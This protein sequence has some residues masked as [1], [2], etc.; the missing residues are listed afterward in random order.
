M[1]QQAFASLTASSHHLVLLVMLVTLL[2][3]SYT[4]IQRRRIPNWLTVSASLLGFI[5]AAW[6]GGTGALASSACGFLVWFGMGFLFYHRVGGIGAGDIKLIMALA[7][8]G[9]ALATLWIAFVSFVLQV[10][11]LLGSWV[12]RGT[13][14][15]N[16]QAVA[17]WFWVLL[18]P[19]A[20]K[21]HFVAIGTSDKSPHAP[22]LLLSTV[23]LLLC[24]R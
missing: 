17:R 14:R 11:W 20:D 23:I 24:E 21:A 22:F 4:D 2:I 7:A 6:T 1:L 19:H 15:V 10:L 12:A 13:A 18:N 9:G 5:L 3:A 8:L 16:L